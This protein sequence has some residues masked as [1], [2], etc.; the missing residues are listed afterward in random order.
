MAGGNGLTVVR[1]RMEIPA[2][3]LVSCTTNLRR[4]HEPLTAGCSTQK[5]S[6]PGKG[7]TARHVGRRR[8]KKQALDGCTSE[9]GAPP[10]GADSPRGPVP[11]SLSPQACPRKPVPARTS[12]EE[13]GAVRRLRKPLFE[14]ELVGPASVIGVDD[15]VEVSRGAVVGDVLAGVRSGRRGDESPPKAPPFVEIE[16]VI[17]VCGTA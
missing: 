3:S 6:A 9:E 7:P 1:I 4:I 8:E 2:P 10:A 13:G 17:S 14:I 15:P 11:A 12:I 5:R 16:V